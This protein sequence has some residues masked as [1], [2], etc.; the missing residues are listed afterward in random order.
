MRV[1]YRFRLD[2][3]G[4]ARERRF[5]RNVGDWPFPSLP[6]PGDVVII[7]VPSSGGGLSARRQDDVTVWEPES[8]VFIEGRPV[9]RVVYS[10]ATTEAFIELRADGLGGDVDAQVAVLM[11]AGFH[12]AA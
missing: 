8:A 5:V 9:H 6:A 11:R 4:E 10:A 7:D 3:P 12:E 2:D 1:R